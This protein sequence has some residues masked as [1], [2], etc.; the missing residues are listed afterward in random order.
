[1]PFNLDILKNPSSINFSIYYVFFQIRKLKIDLEHTNK[2][3]CL[4]ERT[5]MAE[6]NMKFILK[7]FFYCIYVIGNLKYNILQA[8]NKSSTQVRIIFPKLNENYETFVHVGTWLKRQWL[9]NLIY[10]VVY[11]TKV[12]SN[13]HFRRNVR[14]INIEIYFYLR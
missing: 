10:K 5:S 9:V 14:I 12:P 3:N 11:H 1:M 6:F 8:Y 13:Y 4:N 2:Y 7:S